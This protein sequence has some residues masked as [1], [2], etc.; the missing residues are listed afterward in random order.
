M[1]KIHIKRSYAPVELGDGC[2]VFVDRL[3]PR[4]G[5]PSPAGSLRQ[6]PWRNRFRM[7]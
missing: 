7:G 6:P 5:L 2:P 3:W 4:G 1:K